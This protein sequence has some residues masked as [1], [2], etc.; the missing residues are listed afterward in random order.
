MF[1]NR[2][3][4]IDS[5]KDPA[6]RDYPKK[7]A[8]KR[9]LDAERMWQVTVGPVII[10]SS[11]NHGLGDRKVLMAEKREQNQ[12]EKLKQQ[13]DEAAK[14]KIKSDKIKDSKKRKAE[15]KLETL[16]KKGEKKRRGDGGI[17]CN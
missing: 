5:K 1:Y 11:P 3:D 7:I 17:M 16:K 12:A 6:K 2:K 15:E 4:V 8:P 13:E 14:K 9:L 10:D